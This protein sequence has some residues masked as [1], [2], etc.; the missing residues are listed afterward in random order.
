MTVK[1]QQPLEERIDNP[2]LRLAG[3]Q[4][5]IER[6]RLRAVDEDKIRAVTPYRTSR[7]EYQ[8]GCKNGNQPAAHDIG[9]ALAHGFPEAN[10]M[11]FRTVVSAMFRSA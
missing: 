10:S 6:L 2:S 9:T 1:T 5:G 7:E 8:E 3:D 11:R 4:G